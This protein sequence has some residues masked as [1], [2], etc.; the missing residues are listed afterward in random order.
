MRYHNSVRVVVV[1][2]WVFVILPLGKCN[3]EIRNALAHYYRLKFIVN[4][5]GIVRFIVHPEEYF[6][7]EILVLAWSLLVNCCNRMVGWNIRFE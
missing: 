3:F 2:K 5:L 7:I 1:V 6:L 4:S